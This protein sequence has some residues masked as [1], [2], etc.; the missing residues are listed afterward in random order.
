MS[1]KIFQS[2]QF[3][4]NSVPQNKFTMENT[5]HNESLVTLKYEL[6]HAEIHLSYMQPG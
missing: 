2:P 3:C 5:A 4:I 6:P 1:L